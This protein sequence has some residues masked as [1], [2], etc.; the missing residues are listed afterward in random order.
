[1]LSTQSSTSSPTPAAAETRVAPGR[2][3]LCAGL[4]ALLALGLA[5]YRIDAR[6]IWFDEGASAVA[7]DTSS[8]RE[9]LRIA[10]ELDPYMTGYHALLHVW[11][12]VFGDS[13]TALRSLSAVAVAAAVLVLVAVAR[14]LHGPS[15]G[16]VAGLI[17]AVAP[18]A[19]RY[20]QEARAYGVGVLV[21]TT[22]TYCFVRLV[23][24]DDP[25]AERTWPV[26][27]YGALAGLSLYI[28]PFS[29]F[30]IMAHAVSLAFL[31]P[32]RLRWRRLGAT[33]VLAAI[34][35]LPLLVWLAGGAASGVNWIPRPGLRSAWRRASEIAGGAQ[36]RVILA[37]LVV[38]AI[39][40]FVRVLVRTS[41][42]RDVWAGALGV[43]W[44]TVPFT[45][46]F[47]ISVTVKPIFVD[48]YL[49]VSVPALALVA[50][51][52]VA[53]IR[54]RA[55]AVAAVAVLVVVSIQEIRGDYADP[56][57][58]WRGAAVFLAA[59]ATSR[60]G[61][62]VCPARHRAPLQYY[63][64]RSIPPDQRPRSLSPNAEW[65]TVF[66]T[67]PATRRAAA[68]WATGGPRRIWVVTGGEPCEFDFHDR[69]RALDR[70]YFDITL[71]R[72]DR[73]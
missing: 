42:G 37:V 20:G 59:H 58:D 45:F 60:D 39:V 14:R 15:T 38:V 31:P 34:V 6:S 29:G 56:N 65:D 53:A 12:R 72:Y 49:I 9:L 35:A 33:A 68:A 32:A 21:V 3:W 4:E 1:M 43:S 16:L 11:R 19:V 26:V 28:H 40:G 47:L 24:I 44:L 48:R 41:R 10:R 22:L 7:S 5:L 18:F 63:V 8:P 36:P 54:P 69:T 30:V 13:E 61:V 55:L 23:D 50:A 70:E 46:A 67:G 73:G 25:A 57:E 51:T 64:E 2:F 52:G 62:V 17:L 71:E 27:A 66:P